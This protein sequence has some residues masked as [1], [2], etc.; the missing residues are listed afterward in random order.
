MKGDWLEAAGTLPERSVVE[1]MEVGDLEFDCLNTICVH[2]PLGKSS[3]T[4]VE[5]SL[6]TTVR[7]DRQRRSILYN[8]R[9]NTQANEA[10]HIMLNA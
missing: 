4:P 1:K 3:C 10:K 8:C 9:H 7:E 2:I 5:L 6:S